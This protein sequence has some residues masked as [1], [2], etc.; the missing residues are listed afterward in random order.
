M[1]EEIAREWIK[2]LR[3][4]EIKQLKQ[5]LGNS[6]GERCCLGVLSDI[7][8]ENKI[9]NVDKGFDTYRYTGHL[10]TSVTSLIKPI[11]DWA[12]INKNNIISN[13]VKLPFHVREDEFNEVGEFPTLALLNDSGF[14][15]DQIADIIECF[16][17][18]L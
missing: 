5:H 12:D 9:V 15:F 13:N 2:R 4:R 6:A 11:V 10:Y 17:R 1:K 3:S 14:T 8:V 16:W 18:E 7:A